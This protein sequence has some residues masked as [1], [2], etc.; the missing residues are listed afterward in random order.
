LLLGPFEGQRIFDREKQNG[1]VP[2][3]SR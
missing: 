2:P 3:D 1:T